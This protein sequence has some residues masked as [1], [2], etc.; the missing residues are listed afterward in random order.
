[1]NFFTNLS[2]SFFP[3]ESLTKVKT[4]VKYKFAKNTRLNFSYTKY[5]NNNNGF[6]VGLGYILGTE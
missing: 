3:N 4:G 6:A 5:G 1:M 2:F